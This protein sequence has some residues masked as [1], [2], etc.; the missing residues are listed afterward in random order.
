LQREAELDAT[1]IAQAKADA[2]RM[3]I[4]AEARADAEAVRIRRIASATAESIQQVN[5]AIQLGGESY[6]RYRQIELLP[7]IAP[8]IAEALA[9]AKL[10]TLA[11][12]GG[13]A[14]ESTTN[15]ISN[16]IQTV[17]AAQLVARGGPLDDSLDT[18]PNMVNGEGTQKSARS[19]GS[20]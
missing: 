7:Q 11:G 19:A 17:L 8:V 4:D 15:S 3:R 13:G 5:Q 20:A 14:A 6:F 2:A 1:L 10:V 9:K 16:V 12:G 18:K